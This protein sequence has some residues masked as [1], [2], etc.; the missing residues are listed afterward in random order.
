MRL[1]LEVPD[2]DAK[3]S[4]SWVA[5]TELLRT[6]MEA[7]GDS[8]AFLPRIERPDRQCGYRDAG[9]YNISVND[10]K[11]NEKEGTLTVEL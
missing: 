8:A 2:L 9:S 7:D 5:L 1:I 3:H 6:M 4:P 11:G 10:G